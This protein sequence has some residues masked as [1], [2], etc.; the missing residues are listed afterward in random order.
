[1][2]I[3]L[4]YAADSLLNPCEPQ[5]FRDL[6]AFLSHTYEIDIAL[7]ES[8]TAHVGQFHGGVPGKGCFDTSKGTRS[9]GR[10]FNLLEMDAIPPPFVPSWR[11]HGAWDIRFDYSVY[12]F[13]DN[14][15]WN[16]RLREVEGEILPIAGLDHCG[17]N[18][19]GMVEFNLLCLDFHV[20][21]EP[22]VV[23][24]DF[25][26]AEISTVVAQSFADFLPMLYRCSHAMPD[27]DG[28]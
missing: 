20:P 26:R 24:F 27:D 6:E 13:F 4:E 28:Y 14:E 17:L 7:P 25:E 22:T 19:R 8:Y 11:H 5:R 18:C 10:M 3:D 2:S 9:I 15:M 21:G 23:V 16:V 12:Q 1:M